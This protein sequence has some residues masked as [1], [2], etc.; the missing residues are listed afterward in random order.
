MCE[1]TKS[2]NKHW[3]TRT[4]ECDG[5][6]LPPVPGSPSSSFPVDPDLCVKSHDTVPLKQDKIL[7]KKSQDT[8]LSSDDKEF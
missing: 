6:P 8:H 5:K 3:L 2:N 7:H 4:A 1:M